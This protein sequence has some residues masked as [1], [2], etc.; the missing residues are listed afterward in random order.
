MFCIAIAVAD[1]PDEV[2]KPA[3]PP[4]NCAILFSNTSVVGFI[5]LV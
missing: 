3:T 2:A 4:S 1:C 5:I